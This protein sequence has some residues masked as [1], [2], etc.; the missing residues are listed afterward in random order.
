MEK[1]EKKKLDEINQ[2]LMEMIKKDSDSRVKIA[3]KPMLSNKSI[4]V[5]RR[6]KGSPDKLIF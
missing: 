3:E 5:I 2:K 1:M 6:R 4:R